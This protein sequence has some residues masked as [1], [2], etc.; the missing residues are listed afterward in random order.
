MRRGSPQ[1][2]I[3][4]NILQAPKP[5]AEVRNDGEQEEVQ[6]PGTVCQVPID[7]YGLHPLQ[8]KVKAIKDA[9]P[10][11]NVHELKS[12]FLGLLTLLQ[13]V[14]TEYVNRIGPSLPPVME[15][16]DMAMEEG[17]TGI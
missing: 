9:Q 14:S 2:T 10:L 17:D 15:R 4:M 5:V 13:Q 6:I 16:C 7:V 3:S 8:E 1:N 11:K 12:Y